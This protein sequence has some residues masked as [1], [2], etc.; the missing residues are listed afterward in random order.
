[1]KS[2]LMTIIFAAIAVS[3]Q[4]SYLK[5]PPIKTPPIPGGEISNSKINPNV[6]QSTQREE[7]I[8]TPIDEIPFYQFGSTVG[9]ENLVGNE[10]GDWFFELNI[11][12]M[13][14]I[15]IDLCNGFTNYDAYLRVFDGCPLDGGVEIY[16]ND[17]GPVCDLDSAPYEPSLLDPLILNPGEYTIVVDG[18]GASEGNFGISI[19]YSTVQDCS[20]GDVGQEL[21]GNYGNGACDNGENGLPDFNC[22][23][24]DYDAN[25]CIEDCGENIIT[26]IPFESAGNTVCLPNI[27]SNPAGDFVY[28]LS[29]D[30]TARIDI[31]LCSENTNFDPF[32]RVFDGCPLDT[33]VNQIIYNDDGPVCEIDSAYYEPSQITNLELAPGEYSIVIDGYGWSEGDFGMSITYSLFEDCDSAIFDYSQYHLYDNGQCNNGDA[34]DPNLNCGEWN[35]DGGDCSGDIGPDLVVDRDYLVTSLYMDSL[36]VVDGDC[37][38]QEG[39]VAGSGERK[40][41]RFSTLIGNIGNADFILGA[42]GGLNWIWDPCHNHYHYE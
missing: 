39:C 26:S 27:T 32:L 11:D 37:Y 21:I 33:L 17:D 29:L 8:S 34:G 23:D 5:P 41:M 7:C 24:W 20:G 31:S 35:F 28:Q 13:S 30:E 25:D 12:E 42:P 4:N 16:A 15:S 36:F 40:I 14:I 3:N 38:I 18:Y 10:G 19:G 22:C 6:R 9:L 1:M 2:M